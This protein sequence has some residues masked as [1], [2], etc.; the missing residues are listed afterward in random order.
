MGHQLEG[1]LVSRS[2]PVALLIFIFVV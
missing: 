1:E 2:K